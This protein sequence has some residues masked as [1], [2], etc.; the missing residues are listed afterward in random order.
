VRASRAQIA[1]WN[2]IKAKGVKRAPRSYEAPELIDGGYSSPEPHIHI[3]EVSCYV[4]SPNTI[5]QLYGNATPS[6]IEKIQGMVTGWRTAIREKIR[7]A[8][9]RNIPTYCVG[10]FYDDPKPKELRE[11]I[12]MVVLTRLSPG[13]LDGHDN[14]Q[15]SL[16]GA[17]DTIFK[18]LAKGATIDSDAD[19]GRYDDV[20]NTSS[21]DYTGSVD[22]RYYQEVSE[23][24]GLR[25]ELH[26]KQ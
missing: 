17:T 14:L 1:K 21:N 8:L 11:A 3:L 13:K 6:S 19:V 24:Y 5:M 25:I 16:K 7:S 2:A 15:F 18:W 26:S 20:V 9:W 12:D 22:L 10:K 4:P 23:R